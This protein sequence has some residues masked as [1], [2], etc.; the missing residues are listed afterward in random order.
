MSNEPTSPQ[1]LEHALHVALCNND[2]AAVRSAIERGADPNAKFSFEATPLE[3]ATFHGAAEALDALLACGASVPK[4]ALELMG[5]WELSDYM[6][7]EQE[8]ALRYLR[9]AKAL[10]ARGAD[11]TVKADEGK[12]LAE[13]WDWFPPLHHLFADA[14]ARYMSASTPLESRTIE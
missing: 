14:I 1:M 9:V 13:Y 5:D 7:T 2:A 11:P 8:D 3:F 6:A 10:L 4:N 12:S